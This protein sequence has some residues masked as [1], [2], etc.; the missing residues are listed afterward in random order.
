[1]M[2]FFQASFIY[3]FMNWME[4]ELNLKC[5]LLK[6]IYF[7]IQIYSFLF[8]YIMLF[9]IIY[10]NE[11]KI[12]VIYWVIVR[13]TWTKFQIKL[14]CKLHRFYILYIFRILIS[15]DSSNPLHHSSPHCID[16]KYIENQ[17]EYSSLILKIS[18]AWFSMI[19]QYEH[20]MNYKFLK[21]FD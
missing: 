14:F 6:N 19:N 21:G 13:L 5:C 15:W 7:F 8:S 12:L 1:M 2:K 3:F 16:I 4:I 17:I 20:E 18:K 11:L 10:R 9:T